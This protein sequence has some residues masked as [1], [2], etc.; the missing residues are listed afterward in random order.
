MRHE[1]AEFRKVNSVV[2]IHIHGSK[3]SIKVFVRKLITHEGLHFFLGDRA[4]PICVHALEFSFKSG[5][6]QLFV[7]SIDVNSLSHTASELV[8]VTITLLTN[9]LNVEIEQ[10]SDEKKT[11][12]NNKH[13]NVTSLDIF[14]IRVRT[15]IVNGIIFSEIFFGRTVGRIK[16]VTSLPQNITQDFPII[17]CILKSFIERI[18]AGFAEIVGECLADFV[19]LDEELSNSTNFS[20]CLVAQ[21]CRLSKLVAFSFDSSKEGLLKRSDRGIEEIPEA[22]VGA[23]DI[24]FSILFIGGGS[25]AFGMFN[26]PIYTTL[27]FK[28]IFR[29]LNIVRAELCI[30]RLVH[31]NDRF[32]V[33]GLLDSDVYKHCN[34]V[35]GVRDSE[36]RIISIKLRSQ[37][38]T[39]LIQSPHRS[40][41][42]PFKIVPNLTVGL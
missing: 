8:L 12:K 1:G 30:S 19:R 17:V 5:G 26:V 33:T 37:K 41:P 21:S 7:C 38:L 2:V 40:H 22:S 10:D 34:V 15:G 27:S 11:S 16:T 13:G 28:R 4:T 42:V 29:I 24:N 3:K 9:G 20:A 31:V 18:L 23:N 35:L 39:S 32:V 25:E 36:G 6:V 14:I